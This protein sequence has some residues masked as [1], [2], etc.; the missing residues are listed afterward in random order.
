MGD[1]IKVE[2]P[3]WRIT[4]FGGLRLETGSQV[5]TRFRSQNIGGLLAYLA[6]KLGEPQSREYLAE[7]FWP[8]A[9][10]SAA[11]TNLRTALASLRRQLEPPGV[12]GGSVLVSGGQTTVTLSSDAVIVD[13]RAFDRALRL[14]SRRET[15]PAE[16][17]ERLGEAL[18]LYR[19][20]FLPGFYEA[21][22]LG[23]RDRTAELHRDALRQLS[24]LHEQ[25]G[26]ISAALDTGRLLVA[27]DPL[28]EES[29]GMVIRL[30]METDQER[31]ARAQ[32]QELTRLLEQELGAEP[33]PEIRA[34]LRKSASKTA[35]R[36]SAP[37]VP[38]GI[39]AAFP[40]PFSGVTPV[41][42]VVTSEPAL[43]RTPVHLPLALTR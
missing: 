6:L 30:L 14:A 5:I 11:R 29:H 19:G 32:F 8:D 18:A 40:L 41:R 39:G 10:P 34:L 22:A 26:D 25:A 37:P 4:L 17:R 21:W 9:E 43:P 42:P 31:A 20:P 27:A 36:V 23:E 28:A 38:A 16:V 33:S 3:C 2:T 24:G 7:L 35:V 1:G 13:I 15:P 12:A